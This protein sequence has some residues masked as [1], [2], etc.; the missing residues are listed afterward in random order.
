MIGTDT[1]SQQCSDTTKLMWFSPKPLLWILYLQALERTWVLVFITINNMTRPQMRCV[2]ALKLNPNFPLARIWLGRVYQVKKMYDQSI[3]E[4]K[5]AMTVM[6]GWPVAYA[7]IGNVYGVS[8]N[9]N[10]RELYWTA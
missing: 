10:K 6:S 5:K 3:D 7:Q 9:I 1:I 2:A 4:Y 8:G